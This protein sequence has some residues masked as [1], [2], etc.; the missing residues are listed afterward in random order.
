MSGQHNDS[1][2]ELDEKQEKPILPKPYIS[3]F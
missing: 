2:D 3:G 1:M